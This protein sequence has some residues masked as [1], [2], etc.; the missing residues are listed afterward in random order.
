MIHAEE[1]IELADCFKLVLK[2]AQ[3]E[4]QATYCCNSRILNI[5][6]LFNNL[7]QV[8]LINFNLFIYIYYFMFN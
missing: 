2:A 5:T 3:W 6:L 7:N 1:S 8:L 4:M